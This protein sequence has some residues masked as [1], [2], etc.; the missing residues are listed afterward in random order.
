MNQ[1]QI[2]YLNYLTFLLFTYL[3]NALANYE[4][5]PT[6]TSINLKDK[7]IVNISS[8]N[9]CAE[10]CNEQLDICKSFNFCQSTNT[11]Y[12]SA[13]HLADGSASTTQLSDLICNH[14]SSNMILNI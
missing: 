7:K 2:H 13:S 5:F 14:Y 10:K 9:E 12:L 8:S 1:N 6:Q 3:E 11:C 4:R